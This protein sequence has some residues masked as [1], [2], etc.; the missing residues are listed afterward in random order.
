MA[1][2]RWRSCGYALQNEGVMDPK[3]QPTLH[4]VL[5]NT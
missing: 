3:T 1:C 2:E 4:S 5:K